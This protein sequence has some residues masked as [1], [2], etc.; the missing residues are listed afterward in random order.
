[1][2]Q[3][4]ELAEENKWLKSVQNKFKKLISDLRWDML[5]L[6]DTEIMILTFIMNS[7]SINDLPILIDERLIECI[8]EKIKKQFKEINT[9]GL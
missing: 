4:K 6:T 8:I 7:K 9:K 2:N 5:F 3:D 1:M